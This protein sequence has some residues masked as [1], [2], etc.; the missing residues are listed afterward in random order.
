MDEA[1]LE[2]AQRRAVARGGGDVSGNPDIGMAHLLHMVAHS[3]LRFKISSRTA[4]ISRPA[5]PPNHCLLYSW[6]GVAAAGRR[7]A[8]SQPRATDT[9]EGGDEQWILLVLARLNTEQEQ[10]KPL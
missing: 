4:A 9:G 3:R 1:L 6:P 8:C 10:M 5:A 2:H 7:C